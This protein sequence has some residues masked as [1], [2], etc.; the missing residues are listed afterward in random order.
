MVNS[1]QKSD[2][3]GRLLI[4]CIID[5]GTV[6]GSQAQGSRALLLTLFLSTSPLTLPP[7]HYFYTP[8]TSYSY[9]LANTIF[10][11]ALLPTLFYPPKHYYSQSPAVNNSVKHYFIHHH[12]PSALTL[13][14]TFFH[15]QFFLTIPHFKL[16][17]CNTF[18]PTKIHHFARKIQSW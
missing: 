9:S 6:G 14:P 1:V 7:L 4:H 2:L 10:I 8:K 11:R 16:G 13:P 5:W 3:C 18:D 12:H 15:H 17:G